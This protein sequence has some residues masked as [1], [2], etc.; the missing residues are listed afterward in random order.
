M[1]ETKNKKKKIIIGSI[2]VILALVVGIGVYAGSKLSKIKKG[3]VDTVKLNISK[4]VD[5][6]LGDNYLNV[7]L[8][9][10]N[11]ISP[12]DSVVDSDAVYVVSLNKDTKEVK[13]FSVYGNTM[14][15]NNG[16]EIKMKDAYAK[17]GP[18]KAI[19][20]LNETLRLDIEKYVSVNFKAMADTID[21]LGG[22][23]INVQPDEIPHINGY[24]Q[25]IAELM[26]KQPKQ[27][28]AAGNQLVDGVQATGYCRI[29]VTEGG[30]M[31]RG[32]RQQEVIS[33]MLAKLKEA[34]FSQMDKIIDSVFSQVETNFKTKEIVDYG[35]NAMSYK[36][37]ILKPYP[38]QIKPQERKPADPNVPFTDYE[39]IVEGVDC[40]KD[41]EEIH[42]E[43]F[44]E[45]EG[46]K[47]DAEE[48]TTLCAK[49]AV[50]RGIGDFIG[51]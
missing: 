50:L 47:E 14:M 30:D 18:E 35:K 45:I 34:N 32:S 10:V 4:E 29:R 7:A 16:K 28:T 39:E 26:G 44:P 22:I 6:E 31:K 46:G 20:V 36:I 27:V 8:F 48:G 51:R 37:E 15:E 24:A 13:L 38:R 12:A 40:K 33:K 21:I 17:G 25:G 19:S 1:E 42:R 2:A 41:V 9:G 11:V 43:L 23:E 3:K 49:P 5:K